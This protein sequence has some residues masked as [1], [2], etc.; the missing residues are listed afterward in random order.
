[1]CANNDL[2]FG[3]PRELSDQVR[4]VKG[5]LGYGA[6]LDTYLTGAV[7][8]R[9]SFKVGEGKCRFLLPGTCEPRLRLLGR[10]A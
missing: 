4:Q 6:D 3:C 7:V 8:R 10:R 1:M 9:S 5:E 2:P